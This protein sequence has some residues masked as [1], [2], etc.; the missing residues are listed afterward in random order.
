MTLLFKLA[1]IKP[2]F[3]VLS[4]MSVTAV[5]YQLLDKSI[6]LLLK[7]MMMMKMMMTEMQKKYDIGSPL[8]DFMEYRYCNLMTLVMFY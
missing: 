5:I 1:N 4:S 6:L 8:T 3:I 2:N 7:T